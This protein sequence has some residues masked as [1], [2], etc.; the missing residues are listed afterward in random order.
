MNKK[1]F[2]NVSKDFFDLIESTSVVAQKEDLRLQKEKIKK[3]S[4]YSN[5]INNAFSSCDEFVFLQSL[6]LKEAIVTRKSLIRDIDFN[7]YI[8][9]KQ[10]T[11][12]ELML[13]GS[14]PYFTD[15]EDD[16]IVIHHIGQAYDSPFAELTAAEHSQYGNSKLLHNTKTQSWRNDISKKNSF[17]NE[18]ITYWKK[19][20]NNEI[21]F[22]SDRKLK[23][24]SLNNHTQKSIIVKIKDPIEKIFSACS[25]EDLKYISNLANSYILTKQ[26]GGKTIEEFILNSRDEINVSIKCT[27]CNSNNLICYGYQNTSNEKKQRYKCKDCGNVFSLFH[28]AI[29]SGSNLSFMQW[30]K[31]IDCLYNGYSLEKTADLCDI[32]VQAAFDN[33]LRL[34]YA[35]KILEEKVLLKGNIVIDETYI[36]SN[37]KGNR[38]GQF[39]FELV[40]PP[41]KRGKQ[42]HIPGTSK[43]QVCIVC[44]LDSYG[45][46]VAKIAG[47]GNPTAKKIEG[48]LNKHIDKNS[49]ISLYSDGSHAIKK[50]AKTNLY[51]IQQATLIRKHKSLKRPWV[52]KYVQKINSYHSRLKRFINSFNGV[53]S[54]LIEG[55]MCL[56]SWKDRNRDRE[57]IEAYKEL[58][59][60]M[61]TPGYY[62]SINQIVSENIIESAAEIENKFLQNKVEIRNYKRSK[63]IYDRWS[64]GETMKE[65]GAS[66]GLSKQ[67]IQQLIKQFRVR[68]YAYKT[69]R[70]KRKEESTLVSYAQDKKFLETQKTFNRNYTIYLE[71]QHWNGSDKSFYK[72]AS[73]K[74]NLSIQSIKNRLSDVKRILRLRK[75]FYVYEKY[76]Y[77]SLREMIELIYKKY[78]LLYNG[79]SNITKKE[80]YRLLSEEFGYKEITIQSVVSRFEKNEFDWESKEAI[81]IPTSQGLNRDISIFIDF[82][83][84]GGSRKDFFKYTKEK[85]NV[86]KSTTQKILQMNYLADPKR[87]EITKLY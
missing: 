7:L 27:E 23:S 64:K 39:E 41:R 52:N 3:I 77:L 61:V 56:F 49:L 78:T 48:V 71:K 57:P 84:W 87:Y 30:I 35:L 24:T 2:N 33:R 63:E 43:E 29:I 67:R 16:C 37:H 21:E 58:L 69:E 83:K 20:A 8:T 19:R 73:K 42:N 54:E 14:S 5:D 59:S 32:S 66:F 26:V 74:Y 22:I 46:S 45:V 68:G 79:S 47:F 38:S 12:L 50:F 86:S 62:K 72:K 65:L 53:S 10:K 51:P 1:L 4:P 31:F 13:E 11:N 15:N 82:M 9:C 55:Y 75:T 76:D 18:K 6:N 70:E 34:F 85:Y 36:L 81:K 17:Q 60:I 25:V 44:A 28:N 40:R 80:C